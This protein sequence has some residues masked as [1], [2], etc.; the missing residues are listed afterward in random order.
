MKNN[1]LILLI[2]L[3]FT[4]CKSYIANSYFE[5]NGIYDEK[6]KLEHL[7]GKN[8]IVL[9]PMHHLGLQSFY[10]DVQNKVDSLVNNNH[11]VFYEMIM[12][13]NS[14]SKDSSQQKLIDTIMVLKFRKAFGLLGMSKNGSSNYKDF[15]KE[16]G[17][18]IKKELVPQPK[19]SALG[20]TC[21][22]CENVDAT[23]DELIES[24]EEKY[25]EI[26]LEEY[27]LKTPFY[28]TYDKNKCKIK[29]NKKNF[30]EFV[31][32]Y[33]NNKIIEQIN[34]N[35]NKKIAIVYGKNHFIGIKDSL[36]KLGYKLIN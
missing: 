12:T 8:D 13:K 27:D 25:G 18:K 30:D 10:N 14:K 23:M 15:F 24:F 21:T 36:Q 35:N 19:L 26:I 20:L 11:I 28:E 2:I 32:H 7:K 29:V 5:N 33:R 4:S 31:V 9:I 3:I 17:I 6:V 16:K 34:R 22:S 1:F